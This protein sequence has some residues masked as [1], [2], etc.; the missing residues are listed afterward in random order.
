VIVH[1]NSSDRAAQETVAAIEAFG[2]RALAV[3]AD[4]ADPDQL[5]NPLRVA[6][7]EFGRL[8]ILVNSASTFERAPLDEITVAAW[9]RVLAVNLRAPFLLARDAAALLRA[10]AP[11]L[12]VNIADL[13]ALQAWPSFAQHSVSKAGLVQLTRVLARALA[14]G[15]RVNAIAPGTVLPPPDYD[16]EDYAGGR[17]RRLVERAGSPQ[18]V[19]GALLYLVRAEFVTGEILVV[20]GGRMLL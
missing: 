19:V 16:G 13:S 11:G 12:I 18:D 4:L 10:A 15:V 8:D 2:R 6:E 14:P 1:Y 20:D 3:G 5:S 7:A 9:D 17:D